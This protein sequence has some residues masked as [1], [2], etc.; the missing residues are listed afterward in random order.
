MKTYIFRYYTYLITTL[1][2][3]LAASARAQ[4]PTFANM[5]LDGASTVCS[6]AQDA[7]GLIWMGTESGLYSYDGYR[8]LPH[9]SADGMANVRIYSLC[10]A[11]D[12]LYMG[13]DSRLMGYDLRRGRF[14]PQPVAQLKEVRA[15]V[16][17]GDRLWIGTAQGLYSLSLTGH[18]LSRSSAPLRNIYAL[19]PTRRGLFVG[20]IGGLS[21]VDGQGRTRRIAIGQSSA[22]QPLV[23]A[24]HADTTTDGVWVGTEGALYYDDGTTLRAVDALRGNSLKSFA[25]VGD[26]LYA[27]TDNG[28]YIYDRRTQRL[29]HATHD[30]R[31]A[32]SI[33]NNIVWALFR[34]RWGNVWAGTDQGLSALWRHSAQHVIPL[35]DITQSGEGNCLHTLFRDRSGTMWA[36]GT[37][38]L[39]AWHTAG[40]TAVAGSATWYRQHG[41]AHTLSHN[42]VRRIMHDT[43]GNLLVCTDH[44]INVYDPRSG[45]FRSV[46]VSDRT[47]RYTSAWAYDITDDGRGR[48]WIA[49][50][51]GGVF[52]VDRH[53]LL[54]AADGSI[55]TADRH[56]SS[57]LQ[58]IHVWQLALDARGHVWAC[59][60]DNGLDRIDSRTMRVSHVVTS[61]HHINYLIA[62]RQG[63][64]WTATDGEIRH[65]GV[66]TG[67]D[68][69]YRTD[70]SA[71]T[72]IEMLADVE[73]DIW[74]LGGQ[75]CTILRRDG[76]SDRFAVTGFRPLAMWYDK[77]TRQVLLGGNDALMSIDARRGAKY[78]KPSAGLLLSG[79]LVG[80]EAIA[81]E[82][83]GA[84]YIQEL[85]L[86]HD[87]N[88]LTLL[89]TDLPMTGD[90]RRV[91]AY[92]LEGIDRE[93]RTMTGDGMTVSYSALPP[94]D[95]RLTVAAMGGDGTLSAPAYSLDV[96]ILP[97]WYLSVWARTAYLLF[98]AALLWWA[99]NFYLMR[100]RLARE[101]RDKQHV[102]E[103][104]AARSAFYDNLSRQLRQPLGRLFGSLLTMLH[105]GRDTTATQRLE[106]MRR[107]VV[108]INRLITRALDDNYSEAP[109]ARRGER[110]RVDVVD[111]CRRCADDA[112]GLYGRTAGVTFHTDTPIIY[113]DTDVSRL[114]SVMERLIGYA[115]TH[116]CTDRP[117]CLDVSL[118]DGHADIAVEVPGM[119]VAEAELP[120]LF[121]RYYRLTDTAPAAASPS[122]HDD[123]LAAT[124]EFAEAC[125]GGVKALSTDSGTTIVLS[126][127]AAAPTV[128]AIGDARQSPAHGGADT[129]AG[130][131]GADTADARL[132]TKIT[133]AIESHLADSDLN[134]TRLQEHLGIGSKLLYRKVKQMTGKTPVEFIRHI[135]MQ[136]AA[137]LLREGKFSV[138]E[139]MY[140][141][142]YSN[143][144]YFSK[145]F[146]KA[147][148]I[149]PAEY[150]RKAVY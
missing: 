101:R 78:G 103:Q 34:D 52:V 49:A 4:Q 61:S 150:A 111:F 39:I 130:T 30:S 90:R 146:Q 23:N 82:Q 92:R 99:M 47:G 5:T 98:A 24:L 89:F 27:G 94:G 102:I 125:G 148:G 95:Y 13:S 83:G 116:G 85:T 36:G 37:N 135:R 46:I 45:Q 59:M 26:R 80:G 120:L 140:M 17:S 58:G 134:V 25:T 105:D 107:D 31:S 21:V 106:R 62:D 86:R 3:T 88:N 93:W 141:V 142:G 14:L 55:L 29:S 145:C 41:P 81:P 10:I 132:L 127:A 2:T 12:T 18:R 77:D 48:Y 112:H 118:A 87:Q 129:A 133:S 9:R 73:G 68:R 43:E 1:L 7:Q 100:K 124:H 131:M 57:Q 123:T 51:M 15:V 96:E 122:G 126:L 22:R 110:T 32:R 121:N 64:I 33:A 38:G 84:P 63:D 75:Q 128:A 74:A 147:Y 144:S 28:L 115:V 69:T 104:S 79:I 149:A 76:G 66:S 71:A 119:H 8:T 97:P 50:Y 60:Y 40:G 113:I 117:A 91:Y 54:A 138:S 6:I 56:F 65:F 108:D 114:Q 70:A 137:A 67:Q 20:T 72:P 11:G 143:S 44:G 109:A 53:R 16:R 136:R 19:L 42:R 139:V 35:S